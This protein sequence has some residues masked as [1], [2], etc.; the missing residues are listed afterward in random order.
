MQTHN[1]DFIANLGL[2]FVLTVDMSWY[3][4]GSMDLIKKV[5]NL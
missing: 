2:T 1:L 5:F 4:K 3:R